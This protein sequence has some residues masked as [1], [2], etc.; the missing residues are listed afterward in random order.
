MLHVPPE[1]VSINL[2]I[3]GSMQASSGR[4]LGLLQLDLN[5]KVC[6]PYTFAQFR[7][8]PPIAAAIWHTACRQRRCNDA[9]P[10]ASICAYLL[11]GCSTF[12]LFPVKGVAPEA[13]P[14]PPYVPADEV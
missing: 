5:A 13:Q 11:M 7:Y 9:Q 12:A 1:S 2:H 10:S 14:P 4:N 6:H 3:Q 8:A